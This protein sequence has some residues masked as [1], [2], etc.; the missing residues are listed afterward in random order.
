MT[1]EGRCKKIGIV[2]IGLILLFIFIFAT[3]DYY[4]ND[5]KKIYVVFRYDDYSSLSPTDIEIKII[6][7][8][9]KNH[10]S[11]TI[12]VVP[13]TRNLQN[14]NTVSGNI[15]PLTLLKAEILRKAV[16]DRVVNVALHGYLHEK[17]DKNIPEFVGAGYESELQKL[18][19]G[20]KVIEDLVGV[21]PG[22]FIP[23]WNSYDINTLI[24]LENS[25]FNAI[26]SNMYSTAYNWSRLRYLPA[27]TDL[28]SLKFAIESARK[29]PEINPVIV[30]L[31]HGYDFIEVNKE[32]GTTSFRDFSDIVS[33]LLTQKDVNV[34]TLDEAIES[35]LDLNV[36]TFLGNQ[37]YPG[38][39]K[40]FIFPKRLLGIFVPVGIYVSILSI[41]LVKCVLWALIACCYFSVTCLSFFLIVITLFKVMHNRVFLKNILS[42]ILVVI[43][44]ISAVY[45]KL[46]HKYTY[47]GLIYLSALFGVSLGILWFS[48]REKKTIKR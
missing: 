4:V 19:D 20:R 36:N 39:V 3:K 43:L 48:F 17:R 25:G 7:L 8:F 1:R 47:R 24:A 6:E 18:I 13:Y 12:G 5:Y 34:N 33:W 27:T 37:T 15:Y 11:F 29:F 31:L 35:N 38:L 16:R 41:N 22:T 30:V 42:V 10:I 21:A 45:F 28:S 23:P 14:K 2:F 46:C 32:K 44:V 26:S 40:S 9:R